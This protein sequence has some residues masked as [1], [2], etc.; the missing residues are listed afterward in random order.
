MSTVQNSLF[1]SQLLSTQA[2][3]QAHKSKDSGSDFDRLLASINHDN[4][5]SAIGDSTGSLSSIASLLGSSMA[6]PAQAFSRSGFPFSADFQSAFGTTGPLI[7][8]INMIT[9]KLGLSAKQNKALQDI[10]V[11][12]K[13]ITGSAADVASIRAELQQAGIGY[14]PLAYGRAASR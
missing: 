9:D 4:G 10:S 11:R 6:L 14:G 1:A 5:A 7:D 12:H 8:Y 3:Q 2:T 13:D